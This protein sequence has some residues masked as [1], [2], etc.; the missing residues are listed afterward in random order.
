[1]QAANE[2]PIFIGGHATRWSPGLARELGV[3]S[4]GGNPAEVVASARELVGLGV[5]T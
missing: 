5:I 2:R 3:A 4:A 1:V